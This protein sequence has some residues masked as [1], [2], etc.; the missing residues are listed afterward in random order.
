MPVL[1]DYASRAVPPP[2]SIGRVLLWILY[3]LGWTVGTA[4]AVLC[5]SLY[6]LEPFRRGRIGQDTGLILYLITGVATGVALGL[7]ARR[8][9]WPQVTV[10]IAGA[11]GT[12][13]WAVATVRAYFGPRGFFWEVAVMIGVIF[14]VGTAWLCGGGVAGVLLTRWRRRRPEP[15]AA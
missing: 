8:H 3:Y 2:P 6:L 9:T 13:S 12:V 1:V 11:L 10:L 15:I 4:S 5:G 7:V 14:G